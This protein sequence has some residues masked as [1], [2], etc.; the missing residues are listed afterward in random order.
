MT[1]TLKPK[2]K[3]RINS[4]IAV[5]NSKFGCSPAITV[6]MCTARVV[7]P[8]E[9]FGESE[10][11]VPMV[12]I[13][14]ADS[15]IIRLIDRR[16]ALR[17]PGKALGNTTL[18]I[19]CVVEAPRDRLAILKLPGTTINASSVCLIIRGYS[20]MVMVNEPSRTLWVVI[21]NKLVTLNSMETPIRPK[22]IDGTP[23]NISTAALIQS[24]TLLR[25]A[26]SCR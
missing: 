23:A 3:T 5:A 7:A 21:P 8:C 10:I 6:Q 4:E 19:V 9:I 24:V 25:G 14:A 18:K 20:M 2:T 22:I 15:P 17:I 12:K 11:A 16:V 13:K 26:T 1:A